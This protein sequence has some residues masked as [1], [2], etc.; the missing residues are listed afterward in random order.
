MLKNPPIM[1]YGF[2]VGHGVFTF[3][4][5]GGYHWC[6]SVRGK[7]AA[8][9][10]VLNDA[11]VEPGPNAFSEFILLTTLSAIYVFLSHNRTLSPGAASI[12]LSPTSSAPPRASLEVPHRTK[13]KR[14]TA[15]GHRPE[16]PQRLPFGRVWLTSMRNYR[17]GVDEG[18]LT[19]LLLG[20]FIA[21][22]C[23]FT[24]FESLQKQQ[25]W[26]PGWL[27]EEP[28][29]PEVQAGL[30]QSRRGL[31][32]L[33]FMCSSILLV[34]MVASRLNNTQKN[35]KGDDG[36]NGRS[37]LTESEIRRIWLYVGFTVIVT[38]G[39]LS[40]KLATLQ[41][42]FRLLHELGIS[43]VAALGSVDVAVGSLFFQF[44]LYVMVRLNRRGFT[45]GELG[46]VAQGATAI[47][48][49]TFRLT[50]SKLWPPADNRVVTFRD[51][52]PLLI[53]QLALIPGSLLIGFLLSPLLYLSRHTA[54]RRARQR[55]ARLLNPSEDQK[56]RLESNLQSRFLALGFYLFSALIVGGVIGMWT[57][58]CLDRRDPWLWVFFWMLK[59][60]KPW[61]RPVLLGYWGVLVYISVVLWNRQFAKTKRFRHINGI[62][63]ASVPSATSAGLSEP[64]TMSNMASVSA[65]GIRMVNQANE[66]ASE[67]LDVADKH[68]PK[69]INSRRK[70]FHA[71]AVIM[72]LP[73]IVWD[74]A[75]TH[76]SFSVAFALF[77]FAEYVRYFALYPFNN[78]V[79]LFLSEFIDP[80][81]NKD[82]GAAILSHFYLLTG[83]AGTLWLEGSSRTLDV[84]GTIAL[85]IGDAM[86]ARY[87]LGA[88]LGAALEAFSMQNDNLTLPLS[89]HLETDVTSCPDSDSAISST[90]AASL[91]DAPSKLARKSDGK[92]P[93]YTERSTPSGTTYLFPNPASQDQPLPAKPP[94]TTRREK[95][96]STAPAARLT[97]QLLSR[98]VPADPVV[99][100]ARSSTASMQPVVVT[101]DAPA[102][103]EAASEDNLSSSFQSRPMAR[104]PIGQRSSPRYSSSSDM[105][106]QSR[107][108]ERQTSEQT[109]LSSATSLH[110][111]QPDWNTFAIA[112]ASGL[113]NPHR[114]PD[115]PDLSIFQPSTKLQP[116]EGQA[117]PVDYRKPAPYSRRP[118]VSEASSS[119]TAIPRLSQE[120]RTESSSSSSVVSPAST[121]AGSSAS[122][123]PSSILQRNADSET[124]LAKRRNNVPKAM[125]DLPTMVQSDGGSMSDTMLPS[126]SLTAESR[127]RHSRRAEASTSRD[128]VQLA[129]TM[130]L[131]G[132]NVT[133][134]PL[135]LPSPEFELVDPMRGVTACIPGTPGTT[136]GVDAGGVPKPRLNEFWQGTQDVGSIEEAK[137]SPSPAEEVSIPVPVSSC[138][139]E[140]TKAPTQS[141][142]LS[143]PLNCFPSHDD[144]QVDYFNVRGSSSSPKTSQIFTR[145]HDASMGRH[146]RSE[147][148]LPPNALLGAASRQTSYSSA[149]SDNG[150]RVSP[151]LP[152]GLLVSEN[153]NIQDFFASN[154]WLCAPYPVNE[155][156]RR[157]A[158]YRRSWL[159]SAWWTPMTSGQRHKARVQT[160]P[161]C[162]SIPFIAITPSVRTLFC[163]NRSDEPMVVLDLR[164]DWRFARHPFVIEDP[165]MRFYAG[166]PLRT[167][168]G[169]NIGS[170]EFSPRQRHTL[171]E[172]AAVVMREMELWRDKI[173]LRIRD[174][175]QSSMEKFTRECLQID[176]QA[177]SAKDPAA[178]FRRGA[179]EK[180]YSRA[181]ELVKK[182]LDAEG[183][184]VM[185]VSR[186]EVLETTDSSEGHMS[187]LLHGADIAESSKEHALSN[188][189]YSKITEFFTRHPDGIVADSVIPSWFQ[190]ILP[191]NIMHA[192]ISK[193]F[194]DGH[195]L[196][197][198]RAIGV[199][200]LSAVLK[201][202]MIL[203]DKAKSL[204][205]S[206]ISHELR[207]PL[208]GILAAAELLSD[209][210]LN[211][212]QQSFLQTVQA[213]GAS[214]VETVNHVL[215]YTK[216]SGNT[217]AGGVENV[218][219]PAKVDLMQ[220]VE[221]AAEGCWIGFRA[222]TP[223]SGGS[224]IG[225][226]YSP[227]NVLSS[228]VSRPLNTVETVVDIGQR[229]QGWTVI[230]EKG[231]IRRILMN[232]IGNS[233][234]FT[235]DGY[236][237]VSLNQLP[238][239]ETT[240]PSK[241]RLE[242]CVSDT[243]KGIS[244]DFL[245]NQLFHPFSQEN[246]L[247]TGTG[248]GL[249][250]VHS[251][252]RS[253]AVG[254]RL[255]VSST[256]GV[257][258]EIKIILEADAV[259]DHNFEGI[260]DEPRFK[261]GQN[262]TL[263]ICLLGF[264]MPLRST[265][266]LKETITRYL[267]DW[268]GFNVVSELDSTVDIILINENASYL[269]ETHD[270]RETLRPVIVLSSARGDSYLLSLL[271]AYERAGG[272]C[273]ALFKPGGPSRLRKMLKLCVHY[274]NL[275]GSRPQPP[276]EIQQESSAQGVSPPTPLQPSFDITGH[277]AP[278]PLQRR[279][280]DEVR[281]ALQ[282]PPMSARSTT[283]HNASINWKKDE[284][285]ANSPASSISGSGPSSPGLTVPVGTGGMLLKS[286]IGTVNAGPSPRVLIIED[287][288]ILRSLLAKWLVTKKYE[289]CE[290]V[291]GQDGVNVFRDKGKFDIVL[292]DL[293]M[294]VL[295]G[296]QATSQIR[297][298]EAERRAKALSENISGTVLQL[299]AT[300]ILALTGMSS[301]EYKRK[302]FEAGVD[303]YLV[304]P[305]A[306]KTLD[307]MFHQLGIS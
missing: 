151:F 40:L 122:S 171:K 269:A 210:A 163:K 272:L 107:Y 125:Q 23:L 98:S 104:P 147:P 94:R 255:E 199:I 196:S 154:G 102:D 290:A 120:R 268:W 24:S 150:Y 71:L 144:D 212:H 251:I 279:R 226:V 76:L 77:T 148:V 25:A 116:S 220:L 258:T 140:S 39:A 264:D 65:Q 203:A 67:L 231:G 63:P 118:L 201:R 42:R 208:H 79:H 8:T 166:A 64:E 266:L 26:L 11:T 278:A 3:I 185:D 304:K 217:K 240:P 106:I 225:S 180:I 124:S 61:T 153:V 131:A 70:V 81:D 35:E 244:K 74:P 200:I 274:I 293:S 103:T 157:R 176:S 89:Y 146:P 172:F 219:M 173:Q 87:A 130:R 84:T 301:L 167:A 41:H 57:R 121:T 139:Q 128:S 133:V 17:E 234:K 260:D 221:E 235:K 50:V 283:Y 207:T 101:S 303:G 93:L 287:N 205:I 111:E 21:A 265:K 298:I 115:S 155:A 242:L 99:H 277:P 289:H 222:R 215:D 85:G 36:R 291:D 161:A 152:S 214:L 211:H 52:S 53:F 249:A 160:L 13:T 280:S 12:P 88:C 68:V 159:P 97:S 282:R 202:R 156:D 127:K 95:R 46:L 192:L 252:V 47:F 119:E 7:T 45:L 189:E 91:M 241:I 4:V 239:S 233:L 138:S 69:S 307:A 129:A 134:A 83:C 193:N 281:K 294:P 2:N 5:L 55:R 38:L 296:V 169:L 149:S 273:R 126:P 37:W 178:L 114:P 237:H 105:L 96:P 80:N 100:D 112:Y 18:A 31:L 1:V 66:M 34:H 213:C 22:G 184:C 60:K 175:I 158:L 181:A 143:A 206:N 56:R 286:S 32:Q 267:H 82:E 168:D 262:S 109:G 6:T 15:V 170:G 247:Q 183:A 90:E 27:I 9:R 135:A 20:P 305:V 136:P 263:T 92:I 73:G 275:R 297:Q 253:E 28:T 190:N 204:F 62:S 58:L 164:K 288:A 216:L 59:G 197:Y 10:C 132:S 16:E 177:E 113:W 256:E 261:E 292:L 243:G 194:L 48:L 295:D 285:L 75:L 110:I 218:I 123:A 254:G 108:L 250:I 259:N 72:F 230:C 186:F 284:P 145:P 209:T 228:T 257:G 224:E 302:A 306:F 19:A 142:S 182:T 51:P 179:M 78:S 33:C 49:E 300:R 174:R 162:P 223:A 29:T 165:N 238:P 54:Q 44:A 299:R 246:P 271:E 30:L 229:E 117:T 14:H 227:P 195:E 198:L 236:I 232:L 43:F 86:T 137:P 270:S 188:E 248:L 187:V 276:P 191:P 245:Q 141:M